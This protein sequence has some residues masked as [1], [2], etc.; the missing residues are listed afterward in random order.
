[1]E[2]AHPEMDSKE[3]HDDESTDA[4]EWDWKILPIY[5]YHYISHKFKANP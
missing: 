4:P 5:I 1:M 3:R 2:M